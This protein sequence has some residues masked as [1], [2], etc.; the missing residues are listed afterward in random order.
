MFYFC[1]EGQVAAFSFV[2]VCHEQDYA[3]SS[4][5]IFVL[6]YKITHYC[7]GKNPLNIP[8]IL[9][10]MILYTLYLLSSTFARCCVGECQWQ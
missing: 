3:N 4:Q 2:F 9:L 7:Y 8:L 6:S 5:E 10:K 1:E